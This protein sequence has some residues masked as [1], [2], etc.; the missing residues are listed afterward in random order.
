MYAVF[1]LL[2]INGPFGVGK[3]QTAYEIQRRLPNSVLC[4]P[5]FVDHGLHRMMPPALRANF[6][7][8]PAWRHGVYEVLEL[9]LT[10]HHGSVIAPMT[11]V[12]PAYFQDII[13]RLRENSRNVQHFALVA[14]PQTIVAR[15]HKRSLGRVQREGFALSHLDYCLTR[16]QQPDFSHQVQTDHLTISQV[17][18]HI[19]LPPTLVLP[20]IQIM[21]CSVMFGRHGH[22]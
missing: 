19:A 16:L 21:L 3:T 11:L 6:Q 4:D 20:Q 15:L 2:W 17:A 14:E 5:E 1:V 9:V 18:D 10:Q 13:G 12:E 7:D 22:R 8:M